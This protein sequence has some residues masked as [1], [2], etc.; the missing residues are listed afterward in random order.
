MESG[1]GWQALWMQVVSGLPVAMTTERKVRVGAGP[2]LS[3][4][5][6]DGKEAKW[7]ECH[8]WVEA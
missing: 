2:S 5:A 6:L 8:C 7:M 1:L 4:R 3:L